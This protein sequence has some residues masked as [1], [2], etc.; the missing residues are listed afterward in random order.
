MSDANDFLTPERCERFLRW[1]VTEM[2][3]AQKSLREARDK[4]VEWKHVAEAAKRRALLSA[5]RPRVERGGTTTAERDAWVEDQ[6]ASETRAYDI[7]EAVRKAAEDHVRTLRDQ[8]TVVMSLSKSVQTAYS[9]A[10]VVER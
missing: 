1:C 9:L 2:S 5:D 4:E 7:A 3:K 6:A 8:A 10:G